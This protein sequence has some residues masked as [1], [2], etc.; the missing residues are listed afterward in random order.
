MW[1]LDH[2]KLFFKSASILTLILNLNF[3]LTAQDN[4]EELSKTLE[5]ADSYFA[6]GDYI[7]AKATYQ[8]AVKLAPDDAYAK[9]RL[10][11]SLDMIKVQMQQN[12]LYTEKIMRAD[13]LYTQNDLENALRIYKSALEDLPGDEYA[14][15]KVREIEK[16]FADAAKKEEDY[17]NSIA[18]GDKLMAEGNLQGALIEFKK[19]SNLKPGEGYPVQKISEIEKLLAVQRSTAGSYEKA[20]A[21][22]DIAIQRKK[23]DEAILNLENAAKLKPES[24]EPGK[25]LA[26]VQKMKQEYESYAAIIENADNLYIQLDFELAKAEYKKALA[27]KPED[28]YPKSMLDKIDIALM[29]ISKASKSSYDVAI[30]RADNLYSQQDYEQAMEEYKN[31]LRF[32]PDEQYAKQRISD[33]NNAMSLRK[34][35]DEA[36]EQS[37]SRADQLFKE[38]RYDESL[39]EY[40]R[41]IGFRALEQYPKVKIEEIRT[42]QAQLQNQRQ[43]YNSLIT[44]A[45][46]LY[47]ADDYEEA[48]E[49][50]R[51]ASDL[52]P[53]EQY[54]L[55]QIRMINEILGQRD[56]YTKAVSDADRLMYEKKYNEALAEYR[57]AAALSENEVYAQGKIYEIETI[58]AEEEISRTIQRNYDSVLYL[59]DSQFEEGDY[60]T[61]METYKAAQA[62]LPTQGYPKKQMEQI[63]TIMDQKAAQEEIEKQYTDA[64]AGADKLYYGKDYQNALI[65]YQNVLTLKPGETYPGDQITAING[66]LGEMAAKEALDKQY[67]ETIT[68]ADKLLQ[69]KDYQNA[70]AAYQAASSLKPGETY[71]GEKIGEINATLG[72]I[73]SALDKQYAEAIASADKLFAVKDYQ[74]ALIAYQ[75]A[76]TIKPGETYPGTKISEINAI[77]GDI[78]AKEA[79][80]KQ[81]AETIT[82]ADKLLLAKDYDNALVAYKSAQS[83]N[84]GEKYPADKVAEINKFLEG[85]EAKKAEEDKQYAEAIAFGDKHFAAQD[86]ENARKEYLK[87]SGIK[88][89]ESY[90]VQKIAEIEA[91][92]EGIRKQKEIDAQYNQAIAA[93]DQLMLKE[94]YEE[95]RF[96]YQEAMKIKT[97]DAYPENQI[98][99]INR[100]LESMVLE[101]DQAYQIAVSKADNYLEQQDY[102]MAKVQYE[103]AIEI[104]PDEIYPLDKLKLV[105]EQIMKQRQIMQAEYDKSIADADKYYASK[106]YDNA[107]ESYQAS[108]VI[109]PDE[110]YPKEMIRRILKML[111]ERSIVQINKD[112]LLIANN[113]QH[114][115]E[116]LPVP[117]KD[118]KS[119]YIFFR[120]KNVS[121]NDYK[122]IINFGKDQMKNGGVV[123][124]VPA[125]ADLK[126]F[127]VRI[128]AQYKWFSDDNNW[129]TF[130]PE[131]GD[132]EVSLLQISYSD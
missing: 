7:N 54:P 104:K 27:I 38:E 123:V 106:L 8:I 120:A 30:A 115:F 83:L 97:G 105:N 37:I 31:A 107:I 70:L 69:A 45:D 40:N 52:F 68:N 88:V 18:S 14:N 6:S 58:I 28:E 21:D 53:K 34:S 55:D 17:K 41:A 50:Y 43:I 124:R 92:E 65:A 101:R 19:A 89:T 99:E 119:N 86:Y 44:G 46:K 2:M 121:A 79:L 35:Q 130:Y 94:Q 20:M 48:R 74:N 77:L 1:N 61:A 93:A 110:E 23:Y 90:P 32:Q 116:F 51:K 87:A 49:Q 125:G 33:I 96:G 72:E 3:S 15:E 25:K 108:S 114:K 102:K 84:P 91:L 85:I 95:A 111:S 56:M 73:Q 16:T 36:Y 129:I 59:A 29:D 67:A 132:L 62:I 57:K 11:Q 22:A 127:I 71:P 76:S 10:Q 117:V 118:R 98:I 75:N 100:K 63:N 42:I 131:G 128:S 126:E 82:N 81:Y 26:E 78:A 122:L 9:D 113:T 64:I 109:N 103:R 13:E 5:R 47:F 66:I 12:A 80:D 24:P 39:E 60:I 4:T 112:P